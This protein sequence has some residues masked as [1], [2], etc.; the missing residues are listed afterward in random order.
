MLGA[1]L[2]EYWFTITAFSAYLESIE[3]KICK[4]G[5]QSQK[6]PAALFGLLHETRCYPNS[7]GY[8]QPT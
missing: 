7:A 6:R 3:E 1:Y 5:A 2:I 4:V 8:F